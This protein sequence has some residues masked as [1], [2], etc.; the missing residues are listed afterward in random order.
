MK[1][2][3]LF[4]IDLSSRDL[5]VMLLPSIFS[6]II[7]KCAAPRHTAIEF[8]KLTAMDEALKM[9]LVFVFFLISFGHV[10]GA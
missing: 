4:F 8:L 7:K 5:S 10:V 6:T 3:H 2:V 1:R 9:L